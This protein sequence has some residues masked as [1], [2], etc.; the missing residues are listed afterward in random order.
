MENK[1]ASTHGGSG[2]AIDSY[3]DGDAIICGF[4]GFRIENPA[5]TGGRWVDAPGF[6]NKLFG[7][8]E[9]VY[10]VYPSFVLSRKPKETTAPWAIGGTVSIADVG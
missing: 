3:W 2:Y 10:D 9:W 6:I 4:C 5:P 8:G 1:C 7:R